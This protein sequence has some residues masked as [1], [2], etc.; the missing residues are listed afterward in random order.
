VKRVHFF[1]KNL[2]KRPA[3]TDHQPFEF[4]KAA[5]HFMLPA[6]K[7]AS[8]GHHQDRGGVRSA[9]RRR[10]PFLPRRDRRVVVLRDPF[11]GLLLSH[12]DGRGAVEVF[13]WP[14]W[15]P[16]VLGVR[17]LDP[18][19]RPLIAILDRDCLE[20]LAGIALEA[21]IVL[22]LVA[23][24]FGAAEDVAH[25]RPPVTPDTGIFATTADHFILGLPIMLTVFIRFA[26]GEFV[27]VFA[28]AAVLLAG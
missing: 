4:R 21:G 8:T 14:C 19:F 27:R 18:R 7:A 28:G 9:P 15:Q 11:A 1:E 16:I 12:T 22:M 6:H 23:A 20:R 26:L 24:A 25:A 3:L 10:A 2:W 5:K 17:L 13:G